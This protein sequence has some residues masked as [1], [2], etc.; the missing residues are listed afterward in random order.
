MSSQESGTD[1]FGLYIGM[2]ICVYKRGHKNIF[3][4]HL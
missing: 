1:N 4:K 3:K 2:H